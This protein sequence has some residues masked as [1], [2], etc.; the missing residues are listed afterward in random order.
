M[1]SANQLNDDGKTTLYP[2]KPTIKALGAYIARCHKAFGEKP[3][4]IAV[5]KNR[6]FHAYY[7][8]QEGKL[9]KQGTLRLSEYIAI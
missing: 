5:Y 6:K 2:L 7:L 8:M 4:M 9:I 1:Y 3:E